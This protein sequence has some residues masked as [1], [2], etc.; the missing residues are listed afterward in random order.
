MQRIDSQ[1]GWN[2]DGSPA[3]LSIRAGVQAVR[4]QEGQSKGEFS[5]H[6]PVARRS[7]PDP[8]S[9]SALEG[10]ARRRDEYK[11]RPLEGRER[12]ILTSHLDMLAVHKQSV[13]TLAAKHPSRHCIAPVILCLCLPW[14]HSALR[15]G[16]GRGKVSSPHSHFPQCR[17]KQ[18]L[19]RDLRQKMTG[20]GAGRHLD[21][22]KEG[23][24]QPTRIFTTHCS[25]RHPG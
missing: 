2:L 21:H 8:H 18:D 17:L 16:W 15:R 20:D 25:P 6:R 14:C 24:E 13:Q 10:S 3:R 1:G 4:L 9:G 12:P 7:S 5:S 19:P 11:E 23:S 22:G